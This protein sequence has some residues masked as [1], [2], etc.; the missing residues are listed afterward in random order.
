MKITAG[1][2]NAYT[3]I[4]QARTPAYPDNITQERHR[5]HSD[6][7]GGDACVPG[8]YHAG[9][10]SAYTVITKKLRAETLTYIVITKQTAGETPA[11]IV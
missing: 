3:V 8:Q 4:K 7:A 9:E 5:V 11:S 6:K 2:T 1:E 10:A